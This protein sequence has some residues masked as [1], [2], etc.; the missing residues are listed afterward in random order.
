MK[1]PNINHILNLFIQ[2]ANSYNV[3]CARLL[4]LPVCDGS[5]N[6]YSGENATHFTIFSF[7]VADNANLVIVDNKRATTVISLG[8]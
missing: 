6:E 1:N 3:L 8:K 5:L 7:L 2:S 4:S